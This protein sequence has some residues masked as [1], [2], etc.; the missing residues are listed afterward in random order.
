MINR[1]S[2]PLLSDCTQQL[3]NVASGKIIPDLV[4]SNA[5]ILSTYTDRILENKEL[6]KWKDLAQK[7]L[8][9]N[10]ELKKLLN[11]VSKIPDSFVTAKVIAN[12]SGSYIKTITPKRM[13][14]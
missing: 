6:Y 4:L 11:G 13:D 1:F 9:E 8:V 14:N 12:S 3:T 10:E 5:L 7:L 2:V